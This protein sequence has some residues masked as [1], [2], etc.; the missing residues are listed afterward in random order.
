MTFP[1][2]SDGTAE[3]LQDLGAAGANLLMGPVWHAVHDSFGNSSSL[4]APQ[5]PNVPGMWMP[6]ILPNTPTTIISVVVPV[7]VPQ[8][9]WFKVIL[10]NGGVLAIFI[11]AMFVWAVPVWCVNSKLCCR[12]FQR[13]GSR[14]IRLYFLLGFVAN[15]FLVSL[16]LKTLPDITANNVFF[17]FVSVVDFV[18][19]Q[20][21]N[22]L[23]QLT[24]IIAAVLAL[25]F[26]KRI[27]ALLGFDQQVVRADFRDILT[28]FTMTRFRA[29]EVS[30]WKVESLP[31]GFTSRSLYVR[32]VLGYNE[33]QH[34]RPRD[35][36]TTSLTLRERVQLNYDPE[37]DTQKLSIVI[38]QQEVVGGAV[39]QLAPVAGAMLGATAGG[40][41]TNSIGLGVIMGIGAAN[42]LGVEVARVDMSSA[43]INRFRA[44]SVAQKVRQVTD[45]AGPSV[46]WRE[47]HFEKVHLVPQGLCWLRIADVEQP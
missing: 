19:F 4:H 22:I 9:D 7:S 13:C 27:V 43:V 17:Q 37:D 24:V 31:A 25:A 12:C 44:A 36:C 20:L 41:S 34:T 3:T 2:V 14:Q 42:S 23:Q 29:I 21:D 6:E 28:C 5:N 33:A 16:V 8:P 18:C 35:G 26:R 32:F 39:S 15:A 46:P 47:E 30:V 1:E 10:E 45:S 40:G 38:K 11:V